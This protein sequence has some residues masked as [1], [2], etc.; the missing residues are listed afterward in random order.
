MILS[1]VLDIVNPTLIRH[2]HVILALTINL[3]LGVFMRAIILL[4]SQI[5]LLV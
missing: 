5:F 4:L 3:L 1:K 2:S